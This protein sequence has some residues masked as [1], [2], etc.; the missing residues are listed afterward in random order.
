MSDALDNLLASH[1]PIVGLAAY[2]VQ[3]PDGSVDFNCVAK[4][5]PAGPAKQM[6]KSL[7]GTGKTLLPPPNNQPAQY[8]WIYDALRAYVAVRQDGACL[9]MLVENNP[10]LQG[11]PIRETLQA[12]L[13]LQD[14]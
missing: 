12:F 1:L 10:S 13:D 6:L 2:C 5:L 7:I 3:L 14:L 11:L 8:C 9:A 4:N